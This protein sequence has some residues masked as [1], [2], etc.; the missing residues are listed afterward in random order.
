MATSRTYSVGVGLYLSKILDML[1]HST[2]GLPSW[3]E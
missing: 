2:I 1:D 3:M